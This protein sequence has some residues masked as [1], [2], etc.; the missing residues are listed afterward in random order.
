MISVRFAPGASFE[1]RIIEEL[2]RL[3]GERTIHLLDLLFVLRSPDSEEVV[4]VDHEGANVGG[5]A[6]ALLG[7]GDADAP[8]TEGTGHAFGLSQADI[9]EMADSLAPGEG[10]GFMLIEHVWARGLKA[11]I[12]D[13]GGEIM[14]EGFLTPELVAAVEPALAAQA[15]PED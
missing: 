5:I 10:A 13:A 7:L 1:G 4:V 15:A 2:T 8:S 9:D 11:A 12:R 14:G 3:Q 6:A